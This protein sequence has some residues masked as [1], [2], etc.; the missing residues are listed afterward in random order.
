[1][2]KGKKFLVLIYIFNS[3]LL[4][5]YP[6]M[7]VNET[8]VRLRETPGLNGKIIRTLIKNES[9]T[10]ITYREFENENYRWINVKTSTDTGW[11][12]GEY[13]NLIEDTISYKFNTINDAKICVEN[14]FIEIG[15]LKNSLLRLLG[16]PTTISVDKDR[17]EEWLDFYHNGRI[18]VMITQDNNRVKQCILYTPEQILINKTRIGL[19]I[20]ELLKYNDGF[21]SYSSNTHLLFLPNYFKPSVYDA[22]IMIDTNKDGVIT[23]IQISGSP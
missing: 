15:M 23:R 19:N 17:N 10:M 9:L 3:F 16:N 18:T 22:A 7:K 11:V 14:S 21:E 5:A 8:G 1:L 13:V 4:S 12:Y 6:L 20:N 2:K